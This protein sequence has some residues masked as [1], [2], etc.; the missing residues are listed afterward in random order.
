MKG[1][2]LIYLLAALAIMVSCSTADNNTVTLYN[3]AAIQSFT[4]GTMNRYVDNVKSTYAGSRYAFHIDQ[5]NRLI[6]N[7]DSLPM[8]TDKQH[9]ICSVSALNNGLVMIEHDTKGDTLDFYAST[10]SIDFSRPRVF[11]VYASDGS[12]YS[13]YTVK[14]NVHQEDGE[15]FKWRKMASIPAMTGLRTLAYQDRVY[16]F[17]NE[18]G[19]AKAYS[20]Q[21]GSTWLPASLP[22]LTTADAWRNTTVSKDSVYILDKNTLYRSQDLVTWD[23]E[24]S[25]TLSDA[26]LSVM[27]GSSTGELYALT[28]DNEI[29][30]HYEGLNVWLDE[31]RDSDDMLPTQDF[32]STSFPM[33][34]ADST[35]YVVLAGNRRVQEGG[36]EVWRSTMWRKISDY[37]LTGLI[38]IAVHEG[39]I[40]GQWTYM[41]HHKDSIYQLPALSSLQILKYDD[42]LLA[43]GGKGLESDTPAF[44][45]TMYKSRDMGLTW[46]P[47]ANYA[48][49]PADKSTGASINTN[50]AAISATVDSQNNIWICCATT[51][52]VWRGRLTRLGWKNK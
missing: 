47:A 24:T 13:R 36:K 8:G 26:A 37:S 19:Q 43:F 9:V 45:S 33:S 14:V 4:L 35:D 25:E 46:K 2:K 38:D 31:S 39:I 18:G 29:A 44:C 11:R 10:D 22:A 51:G 21:D 28:D 41:T 34:L 7:T 50:A 40:S 20:T 48:L 49:P 32:T 27:F 1:K 15:T 30:T 3:D 16:V 12:G 17:G 6:Y 23:S 42:G 52:E 5:A